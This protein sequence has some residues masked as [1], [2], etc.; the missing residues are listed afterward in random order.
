LKLGD[1][2]DSSAQLACDPAMGNAVF[3]GAAGPGKTSELTENPVVRYHNVQTER[4]VPKDEERYNGALHVGPEVGIAESMTEDPLRQNG[5]LTTLAPDTPETIVRH[6]KPL[7]GIV[8]KTPDVSPI[9]SP[10]SAYVSRPAEPDTTKRLNKCRV[11]KT[12]AERCQTEYRKQDRPRVSP[13][14]QHRSQTR[15][16]SELEDSSDDEEAEKASPRRKARSKERRK[17]RHEPKTTRKKLHWTEVEDTATVSDSSTSDTEIKKLCGRKS[18]LQRRPKSVPKSDTSSSSTEDGVHIRTTMPKHILK[19]PKY[20]GTTSFETFLAQFQNCSAFNKWTKAEKLVYLRGALEKEAGQ[21]LWDYNAEKTNSAKKLIQVLKER[22]GGA[23]QEDKYRIEVKNRRRK[24]GEPLRSL[25]SDIRKLV[26]LAFPKLDYKARELMA[27]DYFIDA[28][29]EPNFALKVRERSPKD[30][31]SAL[32]I[33]LQLEVWTKD[34]DR[35]RREQPKE[36][37]RDRKAREVAKPE[38]TT[39]TLTKRVAELEKQ[40]AESRRSLQQMSAEKVTSP[41]KE[42]A[43]PAQETGSPKAETTANTCWGCGDPAHRLWQCPKLSYAEKK[44][45]DRKRVRPITD[46]CH[47]T[48]I[49]IRYKGKPIE[50]LVDTGS[51]VTIAGSHIARKHRWKIRPTEL[52]SVKTANGERMVI[53]GAVTESFSVGKKRIRSDVYISPDLTDMILG[54]DW[55]KKQGRMVWDFN[56]Q[57]VQFGDGAWI[58]LRQETETGCRRI[59]VETDVILPPKQESIVPIRVSRNTR[60][61]RPF[62]AVTESRK[63]P[64]MSHVYSSRSVLPAKFSGLS[65]RVV[66]ADDRT[67]VLKKGTSLG[68]LEHAEVIEPKKDYPKAQEPKEVEVV[69]QMMDSLPKGLTEKQQK[70]VRE[71]LQENEAI[72]SKGEYDIGRTPLVEYQIDTGPHRPIRQPLRR[73]PFQYLETIDKHVAEMKEHGIIEPA[74][75]PWAS[76]V[77]LVRK[78]DGSLRF[79]IDYRQLN[80]ITTQDSYPLP[81]I[82][83]CLNALQGSSW[84]S[85][86]DLRAGYYNIPVAEKDRDKTAFITRSGC[87]RFTVMPFGLT[88]APSVFQRLMDFVLCGLSYVTCMVYLDDII[89][90]GRSFDEHLFRLREVFGRLRQ[91]NLKL[92]PT[93]CSLFRRSVAFLGHIVSEAGIAMQAEKVQAIRDWPPCRNLT[94]LRAFLGICGY[95]R[96]FVKD[97]SSIAAPLFG[98]MKKGV[99]FEWTTECQ[100]A[101]DTLKL[102]LMSEPILAL[103]K[104]EGTYILD[105]DASDFGL[106][107]ILS[108][109]QAGTEKV[110]AY[111]SRTMSKAEKKYETTR[112]EL[113]AVVN[114][115]K[116]FRQYLTGRHFI[117]RV[118]HAALS[119]LRRTP[120]PMPQLARWLTFI[121]EFDYEVIHRDG[122]RHSNADGLSRKAENLESAEKAEPSESSFSEEEDHEPN[123]RIVQPVSGAETTQDESTFS[124]RESLA[125]EQQADPDFGPLVRLR[126]Q[127]DRKPEITELSTESEMAK[128][129]LNQWEQLEVRDGLVYRR[130][131]GK[132]GEPESLQL[133]TPR[134]KVQDVIRTSHEGQTGGHFGIKRTL[135]QVKRRFYWSTWKAD[136][137][138]F[139][140]KCPKCNEYHRGKLARQGP[141]Q[142]VIAG[143]PYE[144]WYIDLTGPHP[145]SERGNIY[146]L[147]CIDAFT[148]W[149]EAFP[150]RNKEAET[151][152]K[153]LVEQVFCRFGTPISVLSDQGKEVDGNIMRNICRMLGVDKLR[154]TPYKPSTNQVER[155]HRSINS[156]LGKTVADHQ[157]DWDFRLSFAMA[158]YRASRN[159]STGYTPNMLTLGREVR[160][161][162]DIMYG[163]LDD[164]PKESYDDYVEN[165]RDRMTAAF[166][167]A[168]IALRKAAERNKRYYDVRVRPNKYSIGDW[169]YYYNPR[170]FQGKQ[171][172]GKGNFR[173]LS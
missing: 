65:T 145:K 97:F 27:C 130:I 86:L 113:L 60:T 32:R 66:N 138:R 157:R 3:G 115:L 127:S 38:Q 116:Q 111:S 142:P 53:E 37:H 154:T 118:D 78:K 79:C 161:P 75:S 135:D 21:V 102:K 160:M 83:N 107:A 64:N 20:D 45:L 17:S 109:E 158:A 168:R 80:R 26:A 167:E 163:P 144:R 49:L 126:L 152:A 1:Y 129:L 121:E 146:I 33:A 131:E 104:D 68:K 173:A 89:I 100:Q 170:K 51:D 24:P 10:D 140:R 114:G 71:L 93:K 2:P 50:A 13:K 77:V 95:Y 169:V 44:K 153:V 34:V 164:A 123:V 61:A 112:K 8:E 74:A 124:V 136:T 11:Y 150:I 70:Q 147:T 35:N 23:N 108:Q 76:N 82:D 12:P 128:R 125:E 87:H 151:V 120:E 134:R 139:C 98:L 25:H 105:T 62:E 92:K 141:L 110:I 29:D 22:F 96:R 94:E 54:V 84:F 133:L 162:A 39:E 57:Q 28:L 67:Q 73:H 36:L 156:V 4:E 15:R 143:A 31:D 106:G 58:T 63:I 119:W 132:P 40:L 7:F 19:P 155:L 59:Y 85:T 166:E 117:L 99:R 6:V 69:Q 149:A 14:I 90:F 72:F 81:L 30:L 56:T 172:N 43:N 55:L 52:K 159:E 18:S 46:H 5:E 101:F 165:V 9:A 122:K 88:G 47:A 16:K 91:A 48:C 103:P 171:D 41:A 42:A 137:F 148:K